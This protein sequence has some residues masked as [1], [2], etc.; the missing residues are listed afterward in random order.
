M[1]LG[2]G[3][4]G[5]N[6]GVCWQLL[7]S[8][9]RNP[10][11]YGLSKLLGRAQMML[12][13]L[14]FGHSLLMHESKEIRGEKPSRAAPPRP[15]KPKKPRMVKSDKRWIEVGRENIYITFSHSFKHLLFALSLISCK[16]FAIVGGSACIFRTEPSWVAIQKILGK[17]NKLTQPFM[18][19]IPTLNPHHH[20]S[21]GSFMNIPHTRIYG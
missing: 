1:L 16:H 21:H 9:N 11:C 10:V 7:I 6:Y 15:Q 14:L 19:K 2:K 13:V 18:W 8:I 20:S 12:V 4:K 17:C 3:A 5:V